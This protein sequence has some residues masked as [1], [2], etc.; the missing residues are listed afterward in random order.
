MAQLKNTRPIV[1]RQS[2]LDESG[3]AGWSDGKRGNHS[4]SG[5]GRDQ[6]LIMIVEL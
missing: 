5:I 2:K 6:P 1:G 3:G 4:S